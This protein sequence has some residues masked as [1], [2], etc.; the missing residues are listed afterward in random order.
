MGDDS[1]GEVRRV[2]IVLAGNAYQRK[3]RVAPG[4]GQG[5]AHPVRRRGLAGGT[6]RPVRGDP[7]TGGVGQQRGQ[8]DLALGLVDR[9]GLDGGDLV[10]A[11]ALAHDVEPAGERS[12]AKRPLPLPRERRADHGAEGFLR[13]W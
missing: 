2:E 11:E 1:T 13:D 7:F 4:I 5:C 3:Q 10:L 12:I 9:G 8:L 6:H